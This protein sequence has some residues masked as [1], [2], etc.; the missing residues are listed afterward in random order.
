MIIFLSKSQ[1]IKYFI[2]LL[3]KNS[4]ICDKYGLLSILLSYLL[5]YTHALLWLKE[6]YAGNEF[7]I[8]RN[9]LNL[10]IIVIHHPP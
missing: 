9:D 7:F 4:F 6:I 2:Y 3:E 5:L 8:L 10:S 1:Y